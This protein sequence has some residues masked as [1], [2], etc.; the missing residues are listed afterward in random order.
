MWCL[1]LSPRRRVWI[2]VAVHYTW[3]VASLGGGGWLK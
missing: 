2:A 3:G 1:G